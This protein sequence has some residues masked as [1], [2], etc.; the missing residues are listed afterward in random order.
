[1]IKN[2]IFDIGNV[3]V[4]WDPLLVMK[5]TF[6]DHK[7]PSEMVEKICKNPLWYDLNLGKIT[8]E[9]AIHQYSKLL[10]E[11]KET[12]TQ[13]MHHVKT[14]QTLL[15]GSVELIKKLHHKGYNLTILS[16][17]VNEVITHLKKTYN[18][19]IYFKGAVI[20]SE[21]GYLKPQPEIFLTL[22][23][24]CD[25]I[26]GETLF[27]DD[28]VKNVEGARKLG[29]H[30]ILFKDAAQAEKEMENYV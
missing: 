29:I 4:R 21:V 3:I 27:F 6:P 26:P 28:L 10:N 22:I 25:L 2:I 14:T 20:S 23:E 12:M 18:F 9:E 19:W 16:D 8:E 1:M 5:R 30:A 15:P 7:N 13:L 11:T 24:K 17:N